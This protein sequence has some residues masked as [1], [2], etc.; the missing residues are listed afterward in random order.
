MFL[1]LFFCSS[2]GVDVEPF[3]VGG[4]LA[5]AAFVALVLADAVL[6]RD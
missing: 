4:L 6:F 5:A 2:S 1:F 3:P